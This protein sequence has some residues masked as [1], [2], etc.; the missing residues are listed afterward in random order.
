MSHRGKIIGTRRCDSILYVR[1]TPEEKGR[2]LQRAAAARLSASRYLVRTALDGR[3]PPTAEERERL[4]GWLRLFHR[5]HLSLTQLLTNAHALR[6]AGADTGIVQP[7]QETAEALE[8]LVA[9]IR[10]RL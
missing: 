8:R 10:R 3:P 4:E 7:L 5:A 6:M 1:A 2:I 9:D